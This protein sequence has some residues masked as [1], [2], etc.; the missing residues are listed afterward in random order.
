[1]GILGSYRAGSEMVEG[2]LISRGASSTVLE[3]N[4]LRQADTL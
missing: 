4:R 1:V 3:A 2:E